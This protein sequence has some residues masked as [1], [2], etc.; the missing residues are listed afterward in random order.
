MKMRFWM[1]MWGCL[2]VGAWAQQ[3][4]SAPSSPTSPSAILASV[5]SVQSRHIDH[6]GARPVEL[7]CPRKGP[8]QTRPSSP[9]PEPT[10]IPDDDEVEQALQEARAQAQGQTQAQAKGSTGG[11]EGFGSAKQLLRSGALRQGLPGHLSGHLPGQLPGHLRMAIWGDS[12]MAAAFFSDHLL[13]QMLRQEAAADATVG[14]RF[15]HAGVGHGG[16]RALVRKTC[17]S[18]DWGREMAYA[19]ADAAAAP[20]PGMTSLLAKRP[21]ATLAMDLRDAQGQARHTRLQILHHGDGANAVRLAISLNGEA[22]T[23]INLAAQ[24]GPNALALST[25]A[26]LSTL[27]IRVVSGAFR[28]QGL[29]LTE[30][31]TP[32]LNPTNLTQAIHLDLFAY[33]GATMA[34]WVRSDLAYLASWFTEQPYDLALIAFGTNEGNDPRFNESAYRDTLNQALRNFRQVFP[35]TQCVL[36]G[37]GDRGIRVAKPKGVKGSKN[38]TAA[39][40]RQ[41]KTTSKASASA[42]P[43]NTSTSPVSALLKYSRIHALIGQIQA[44]VATQNGCLAWRMQDAMGGAGSAYHWARKNPPL[45]APDLIHFTPA[46]YRELADRFM[47]DFGLSKP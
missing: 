21:G 17:L 39:N 8:A 35:Q 30:P 23:T 37:P 42:K 27:Q 4:H 1:L 47:A 20:G 43:P 16:V 5:V 13:R 44:D 19:H 18:G 31:A 3:T 45:M 28:F 38:S 36:I 2:C 34:G 11:L 46:G 22:E 14:S 40:A 29:K 33:P 7:V 15:V 25:N 24:A 41:K 10:E 32:T 6:T 26:P 12:H 9:A